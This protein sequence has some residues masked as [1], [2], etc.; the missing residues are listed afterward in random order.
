MRT[1]K[2]LFAW[3]LILSL[4]LS[5][6]AGCDTA[7]KTYTVTWMNGE[8]VLSTEVVREGTVP[9]FDYCCS[10]HNKNCLFHTPYYHG[11]RFRW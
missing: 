5:T 6:V 3:A 2:K 7:V 11:Y 10:G 8:E 9:I 1:T 4:L